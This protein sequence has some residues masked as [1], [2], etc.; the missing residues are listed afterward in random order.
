MTLPNQPA[1]VGLVH[2][3]RPVSTTPPGAAPSKQDVIAAAFSALISSGLAGAVLSFLQM[4]LATSLP[5]G[6]WW[7]PLAATF[8]ASLVK[9]LAAMHLGGTTPPA[10]DTTFSVAAP[11]TTFA[12]QTAPPTAPPP[13]THTG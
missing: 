8:V 2:V 5:A 4:F 6:A 12:G 3:L 1:L 10:I 9:T 11:P 7:G 13:S